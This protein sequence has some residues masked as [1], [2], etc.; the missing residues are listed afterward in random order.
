MLRFSDNPFHVL[1][2][3]P[4]CSRADVEREGQRLLGMMELGLH[5][6]RGY[7]T[8]LGERERTPE[9]IRWAMAELRDPD[10]RL[11][12][13]LWAQLGADTV[14]ARPSVTTDETPP[15][16]GCA[17]VRAALGWGR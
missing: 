7:V 10:K 13:E 12:H 16:S 8:P 1:G 15:A 11:Q 14:L 4:S 6:A 5:Q 2:L 9:L 17:G 3:K